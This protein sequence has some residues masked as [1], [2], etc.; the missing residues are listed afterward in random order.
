MTK[1]LD[2]LKLELNQYANHTADYH[3]RMVHDIPDTEVIDRQ[4]YILS[5][6][7]DK[8]VLDVGCFG[9]LH[10]EIKKIAKIAYGIDHKPIEGDPLFFQIEINKIPLPE[11]KDVDL[12]VCGEVLEH[13][14]NPGFFLEELKQKYSCEK[15]FSVPNA[16]GSFHTAWTKQGKEN[17]NEDHV[18]YYSYK[19]FTTLLSRYGYKV[20]EFYWYD[21]PHQVQRQG[22]NEGL[23]FLTI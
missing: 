8:V 22:F 9:P 6:C 14:S 15:V 17:V 2:E 11:L 7:V 4:A 16:F 3:D 10:N 19:T 18:C 12:V 23:V 21:N 20:K 13:L 5:H 1:T